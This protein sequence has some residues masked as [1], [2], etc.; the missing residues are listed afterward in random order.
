MLAIEKKWYQIYGELLDKLTN[1]VFKLWLGDK[2]WGP[3]GALWNTISAEYVKVVASMRDTMHVF[4]RTHDLRSVFYREELVNWQKAKGK[5]TEERDGLTCHIL[6]GMGSLDVEEVFY[7]EKEAKAF[8][9]TFLGQV[10]EMYNKKT[11][12]GVRV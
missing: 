5:A 3:Q 4:M 1:P 9:L 6:V 10:N 2:T 8:L 12:N 11:I 7:S